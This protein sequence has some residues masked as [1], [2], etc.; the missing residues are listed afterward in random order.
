MCSKVPQSP[1]SKFNIKTGRPKD[2]SPSLTER[3]LTPGGKNMTVESTQQ[4]ISRLALFRPGLHTDGIAPREKR[5]PG[6]MTG[7]TLGGPMIF[8]PDLFILLR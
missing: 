4:L 8:E 2:S 1:A 7:N 5:S 3:S 6:T